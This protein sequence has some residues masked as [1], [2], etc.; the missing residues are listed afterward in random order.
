MAKRPTAGQAPIKNVIRDRE[1]LKLVSRAD[2][3]ITATIRSAGVQQKVI[4]AH[5]LQWRE[6]CRAA[7]LIDELVAAL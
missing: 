7:P 2:G 1:G 5:P 4:T 3:S 6:L